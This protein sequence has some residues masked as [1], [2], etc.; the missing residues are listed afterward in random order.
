VIDNNFAVP[1]GE[2]SDYINNASIGGKAKTDNSATSVDEHPP[3]NLFGVNA[4]IPSGETNL[5]NDKVDNTYP[6]TTGTPN[7]LVDKA[8]DCVNTANIAVEIGHPEVRV[9]VE[10]NNSSASKPSMRII[11]SDNVSAP[12]IS[13]L[14]SSNPQKLNINENLNVSK[15]L[16]FF[17]LFWYIETNFTQC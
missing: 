1:T 13:T 10:D 3:G 11:D 6:G 2:T 12:N 4:S 9:M 15:E 5:T 17:L 8:E 16:L 7:P 14:N